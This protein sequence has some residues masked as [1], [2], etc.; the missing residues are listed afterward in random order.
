MVLNRGDED[1]AK[2]A[3]KTGRD[4]NAVEGY[5]T[6]LKLAQV[7]AV[8]AHNG[9]IL[10]NTCF[11]FQ[12][13][14]ED[15]IK[16]NADKTLPARN[17][18][19]ATTYSYV[20]LRI[21]PYFSTYKGSSVHGGSESQEHLQFLIY[22]NDPEHKLVHSTITQA[23]PSKWLGLW[24]RYDWVEDLVAEALRVGVEVVGQEY[25]VARMGWAERDDHSKEGST[26]VDPGEKEDKTDS[27]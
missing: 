20:Y 15:I 21:Q 19:L 25:V 24:D 22:L 12:V 1:R 3:G 26:N 2:D 27:S 11:P 10:L 6:A 16:K 13:N 18:N 5:D 7:C 17:D 4:I 23:V 14:V 9:F 8:L